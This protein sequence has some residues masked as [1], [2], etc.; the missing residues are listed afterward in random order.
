MRPPK[1]SS[2][3]IPT[4]RAATTTRRQRRLLPPAGPELESLRVRSKR[5]IRVPTVREVRLNLP[6]VQRSKRTMQTA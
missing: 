5:G 2:T 4:D 3:V 1:R 6:K